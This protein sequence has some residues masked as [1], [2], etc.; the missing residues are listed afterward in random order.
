MNVTC[1]TYLNY[2]LK[3]DKYFDNIHGEY[4]HYDSIDITVLFA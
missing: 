4:R 2:T 3:Y 1:Q